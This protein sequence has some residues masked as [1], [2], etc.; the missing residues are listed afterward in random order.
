M[1]FLKNFFGDDSTIVGLCGFEREKPDY[2]KNLARNDFFFN[3]LQ[4]ENVFETNFT[5]N[6]LLL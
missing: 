3:N 1:S 6:V 2:S 4:T 5:N